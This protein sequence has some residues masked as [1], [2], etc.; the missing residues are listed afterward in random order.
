MEQEQEWWNV[1]QWLEGIPRGVT[2]GEK[3][4]EENK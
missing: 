4:A 2:V 3:D 1:Q